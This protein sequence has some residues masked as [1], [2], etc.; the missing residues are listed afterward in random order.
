MPSKVK[1]ERSSSQSFLQGALVL[2]I[3]MIAVKLCGLAQK[4]LLTNLYGTLDGNYAEF[5]TA[6]FSNAYELYV[7]FFTLATLG[8]PIAV[9]RLIS[10]NYAKE[11]YNDI[12]QI[13]KVAKPFF[14]IMGVICFL[15]MTFGSFFYIRY[16]KSPYSLPAILVLA[17]T[18]FFGCLVSVYRG[19][20]EGLRDMTPTA[21]S[22][23]IEAVSKIAIGVVLSYIIIFT[24]SK[25][26][27]STGTIFGMT[28]ASDDTAIRTLVSM[29][30]AAS[31]FGITAGSVLSL[32]FLR[33]RYSLRKGQIPEEF[34][35]NSVEAISKKQTFINMCKTAVPIGIGSLVMSFANSIDGMLIQKL[36][37]KMAVERPDELIAEFGTVLESEITGSVITI[38][39]C[40]W[41]YCTA[42]ITLVTIVTAVTQ[43]FGTSAMP[44]V[45]NAYTKGNKAELKE[46]IETVLKL[47]TMVAFPCGIGLSVLA[48]PI[49]SLVYFTNPNIANFGSETLQV[50]GLSVLFMGTVTP[51]CSMLQGVGKIKHTMYIYVFGTI[52]KVIVSYSFARIIT[53]NI[54]GSAIGSLVANF[55]MC[56]VALF[57][58]IKHTKIM[59]NF[60]SVAIKPM[61][62]AIVCGI[63]AY[64]C[65]YVL[66]IHVVISIV[67][68]AIIYIITLL[69]LHTFQRNE[70]LMLPK[71]KKIV[72]ILEKLHLIR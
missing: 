33:I 22:E 29:S 48:K 21:V 9:S 61:I 10:E 20:F 19:Y 14:I 62:G 26:Y 46:S 49:L 56:A 41:G 13:Y 50:M 6:L 27:A 24:G 57:L 1:K 66:D 42:A 64:I 4:V 28:F 44:N 40:I 12:K 39:T 17:P 35:A 2:T 31:I 52:L 30:V 45:T 53:I 54:V 58:L 38:H 15:M 16:I 11:R 69:I 5:G 8:F 72:I 36:I 32:L 71:G 34:Y 37:Y 18:T 67:I 47:T 25:Q 23:I 63:C 7:P 51:I 60:L 43:V 59:P 55:V 3:S 68:S 65:S 70:V